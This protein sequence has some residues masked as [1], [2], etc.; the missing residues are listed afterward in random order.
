MDNMLKKL[1][2]Y[3]KFE[4]NENLD[5]VIKDSVGLKGFSLMEEELENVAGGKTDFGK[6]DFNEFTPI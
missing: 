3:Q 1:F 2:D 6:D 5:A 4:N